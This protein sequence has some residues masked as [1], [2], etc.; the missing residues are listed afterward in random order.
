[1][2]L[3]EQPR[4]ISMVRAFKNAFSVMMSFGDILFHQLHDLHAGM[5]CQT[6]PFWSKPQGW[7]RFL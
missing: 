3:V 6:D 4:A 2:E 7:C 5:L 1:M